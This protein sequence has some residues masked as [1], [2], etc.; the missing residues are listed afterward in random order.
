VTAGK[1]SPRRLRFEVSDDLADRLD[2]VVSERAELSRSQASALIA[3]GAVLVNGEPARK[4]YRPRAGDTIEVAIPEPP[5]A[6]LEPEDLPI[7]IV[8]EDPDIVVVDKPAGMVVHPAPGHASGT[9]VNALLARVGDLSSIGLPYRPGIVHRLDR[10]TSGLLVVARSDTAHRRLA[11]AL[12]SRTVGRRYI[13]AVWGRFDEEDVTIDRPIARH[14]RDRKRMAVVEGGREAIT[15]VRHLERWAAADLLA[16]R[17]ETGRTHQIRVHLSDAGHP[18]V[19]DPV[20]GAGWERGMSGAGGVWAAEFARRSG[21]LFL[22][23]ARLSFD[24]PISG[25]SLVF[26]SPL[27]EPLSSAVEWARGAS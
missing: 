17:L 27:P 12:A 4:S 15:H 14:P 21:R 8:H 19:G 5:P 13:A 23:A 24:H 18:I 25:E 20:Y 7:T 10:D 3:D 11:A 9:M 22:H 6:E 26:T 16:L 2:A 1:P